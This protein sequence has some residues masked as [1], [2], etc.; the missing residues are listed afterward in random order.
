MNIDIDDRKRSEA[1][2]LRLQ[3]QI[4]Q[5][6]IREGEER[7]RLFGEASH[8]VLW[9]RD[10]ENFQ[11]TY[12]TPAFETIYGLRRDEALLGDNYRSWLGLVV[13]EDRERADDNIRRVRAGE[14][15]TFE[16]RIRRPVDGEIHGSGALIFRSSTPP[17][18]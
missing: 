11:W 2:V 18:R 3:D 1:E 13:M 14:R 8:D 5:A 15:A 17:A 7:L 12:L 10:A 4:A 6:Q 9:I 16:Y